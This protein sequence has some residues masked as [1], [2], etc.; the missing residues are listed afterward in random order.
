MWGRR[1]L[2]ALLGRAPGLTCDLLVGDVRQAESL[3]TVRLA[4]LAA[5]PSLHVRPGREGQ[6]QP[7]EGKN[8]SPDPRRHG[9]PCKSSSVNPHG[10]CALHLAPRAE[11]PP[12]PAA[13]SSP[14]PSVTPFR[15]PRG[16]AAQ[17]SGPRAANFY[18]PDGDGKPNRAGGGSS[19]LA[20]LAPQI[21]KGATETRER[22][23]TVSES[24]MRVRSG[25]PSS[26]PQNPRALRARLAEVCGGGGNARRL[27]PGG[28]WTGER[29]CV[30]ACV[31]RCERG[32]LG[33]VSA[34]RY[35]LGMYGFQREPPFH[36]G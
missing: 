5:A 14:L 34:W 6:Q 27:S 35:V 33:D 19:R 20:P 23:G 21:E 28:R 9:A 36:T 8:H 11:S 3:G 16:R 29:G 18:K 1:G 32:V 4:D 25:D 30:R 31:C 2:A 26:E 10:P 7:G 22:E 12:E 15:Q 24:T 13:H 17:P